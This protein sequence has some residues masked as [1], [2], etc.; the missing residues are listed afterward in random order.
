MKTG[1][2]VTKSKNMLENLENKNLKKILNIQK[3]I[4]NLENF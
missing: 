2:N 4:K 3:M 1:T